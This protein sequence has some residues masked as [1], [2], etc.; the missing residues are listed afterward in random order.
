MAV[1]SVPY[2]RVVFGS[3][4]L[5]LPSGSDTSLRHTLGLGAYYTPAIETNAMYP[6]DVPS[7]FHRA[8][9]IFPPPSQPTSLRSVPRQGM[10]SSQTPSRGLG[11]PALLVTGVLLI[12]TA[13]RRLLVRVHQEPTAKAP[14]CVCVTHSDPTIPLLLRTLYTATNEPRLKTV[15]RRQRQFFFCLV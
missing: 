15:A 2:A 13:E 3:Y 5:Q 6:Q 14:Q 8:R 11:I 7:S 10:R 9:V 4:N 1:C 12:R